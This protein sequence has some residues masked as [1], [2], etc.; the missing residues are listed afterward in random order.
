MPN[1]YAQAAQRIRAAKHVVAFT[2]AGISV[3]SGIPP[4]RG[5]NGLW[6]KYDPVFLEIEYFKTHPDVSWRVLKDVFYEHCRRATPNPAHLGLA[7][8]EAAGLLQAVVTQNID[9]LHQDAGSRIVHEFHGT[10]A[11][12]LCLAC[13]RR[14]PAREISLD[15]LPPACGTCGGLLKPDVVFFGEPIPDAAHD[16]AIREAEAADALLV[17]GSTGEVMPAAL[18]PMAAKRSGAFVIE[19]NPVRSRFTGQITDLFLQEKAGV[20]VTALLNELQLE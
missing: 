12:L 10:L 14:V 11:T 2:G 1:S 5:P 7:R 20:A 8:M 19:I 4:F 6:N 17:I 9:N 3:E 16:A 15:H 18:I 13:F